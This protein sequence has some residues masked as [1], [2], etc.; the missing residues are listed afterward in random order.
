M[1]EQGFRSSNLTCIGCAAHWLILMAKDMLKLD[2]FKDVLGETVQMIKFF[3]N[4]HRLN[5]RLEEAQ[6]SLYGAAY[7]LQTPVE[8]RWMSHHNALRSQDGT[9]TRGGCR[10]LP[11]GL[12]RSKRG[13]REETYIG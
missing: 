3:K 1:L 6:R 9:A 10:G 5:C 13:G 7:S 4:K 11:R 2:A 12:R 8:T